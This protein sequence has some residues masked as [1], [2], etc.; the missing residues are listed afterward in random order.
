MFPSGVLVVDDD[1][2]VLDLLKA[3]LS[4]AGIECD[5]ADSADDALRQVEKQPYSVV[6]S[7]I[8]MPGMNGV[9]LI[10]ALKRHSP[11]VQVIMR[12]ADPSISRV[13]ECAD[14]G[15]VDFYSKENDLSLCIES[16]RAAQRR[17]DRWVQLMAFRP[18]RKE[19]SREKAEAAVNQAQADAF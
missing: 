15:A 17:I 18:G 10:S 7:D 11:L 16:V 8:N 5:T 2:D 14:R 12:T 9:E 4:S 6:I 3:K 13:I 19:P 1:I